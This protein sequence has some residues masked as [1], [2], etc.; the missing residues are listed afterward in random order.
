MTDFSL[1][2]AAAEAAHKVTSSQL[3]PVKLFLDADIVVQ[4][5][6]AG[7]VLASVWVWTIIVSFGLRYSGIKAGCD[8]YERD[9]WKASDI[10]AFQSEHGKSDI[11]SDRK[12]VV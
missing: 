3:N 1:L 4:L 2:V 5:V 6:I 9:F 7:L 10:D 12:S 11:P 8:A